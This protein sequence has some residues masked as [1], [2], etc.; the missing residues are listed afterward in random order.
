[1]STGSSNYGWCGGFPAN[2]VGFD[3]IIV[4]AKMHTDI[5]NAVNSGSASVVAT[6][7]SGSDFATMNSDYLGAD[8]SAKL[9]SGTYYLARM[10]DDGSKATWLAGPTYPV[11]LSNMDF[12]FQAGYTN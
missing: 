12:S 4:N 11:T 1:M 2:C 10:N 5:N 6:V 9:K 7:F 3:D 8:N